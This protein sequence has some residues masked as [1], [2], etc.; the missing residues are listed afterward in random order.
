MAGMRTKHQAIFMASSEADYDLIIF[1]ETW[2]NNDFHDGEFFDTNIYRVFR[3]DRDYQKMGCLRGGGVL[4]AVKKEFKATS[5]ILP[6]C[7]TMLDQLCLRLDGLN[8]V[9]FVIVSYIPPNSQQSL[10]DAHLQNISELAPDDDADGYLVLGDYN[11]CKIVWSTL[12][13]LNLIYPSNVNSAIDINFL[14]TAFSLGL[15]QINSFY[16]TLD[17]LLDLVFISDNVKYSIEKCDQP[18]YP[19][20]MH[21]VPII[22]TIDSYKFPNVD[23][24]INYL[25]DFKGCNFEFINS[26]ILG[27]DWLNIFKDRSLEDC[28]HEFVNIIKHIL[29]TYVPKLKPY[30]HKLPWYTPGLKKIKNLRNKYQKI[31]KSTNC[32]NSRHMFE[33]YSR[34]FNCLNKYLYN[35]YILNF[36]SKIGNNPKSFFQ[37]IRAKSGN[38]EFP[39]SMV[40]R[41]KLAN[42]PLEQ[43]NLFADFF[44]SNFETDTQIIDMNFLDNVKSVTDLGLLQFTENDVL[45]GLLKLKNTLKLDIDGISAFFLKKCSISLSFA[46]QYIFNLSLKL[47]KFIDQWKFSTITPVHKSGV[48]S[49]ISNYRPISKLSNVSKVFEHIVYDKILHD[50][51]PFLSES[52]H[53]FIKKRSTISNLLVFTNYCI[54]SIDLGYQ[55]DTVYFDFCKAFDKV[56]HARLILKL[57]KIGFHSCLLNWFS[58]YLI[59]RACFV[60][61][62]NAYSNM[63]ISSSG[64]P[65][66]SILGPL[67]FNLFINDIESCFKFSKFLMYADDLK[68]FARIAYVQDSI[69]LQEDINRLVVWCAWNHLS[70]NISKCFYLPFGR[71]VNMIDCA[72]FINGI[73]LQKVSKILDLGIVFD[74]RLN[75]KLHIEYIM[76]KVYSILAFVKRNCKEFTNPYTRKLLFTTFVRSKLDYGAIIWNPYYAVH[77]NR[78]ELVQK[79][80]IKFA[81]FSIN[82]CSPF[83][84]YEARCR[85]IHL[86]TLSNRRSKCSVIFLYKLICGLIDCPA[87]L[88]CIGINTPVRCL[89]H[90]EFF[91]IPTQRNNYSAFEPIL[92]SLKE[93]ND[94]NIKYDIDFS[95]TLN[96]FREILDLHY[97]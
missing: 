16:N 74:S 44:K 87:L 2:L 46:L 78:I 18:F 79:K 73:E 68:L 70:L 72:Y 97:F 23:N 11:L 38:S 41:G 29:Q 40:F 42:S 34:E 93:Y 84:S 77:S 66:G 92:R 37:F 47:G 65:Q 88:S 90:N 13:N 8:G 26:Y 31:Y 57:E 80:F 1:V 95:F 51:S 9:L 82:F 52:Q 48:K 20:D 85:L 96:A 19:S 61:I 14:D 36:E 30:C 3:K 56:S 64:I 63:Y 75:F 32:I 53:G 86:E 4:I 27:I 83:P 81:L 7:D 76:P 67:L 25:Y 17:R 35:N 69:L 60:C 10:Y 55:I 24:V 59:N 5:L 22:L 15:K 21:H 33:H 58:S 12:P 39:S 49:D 71:R 94:I 91:N 43:A 89:R 6:N 45:D 50:I 62:D 54:K 28:Y